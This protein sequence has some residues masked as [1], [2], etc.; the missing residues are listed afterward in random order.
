MVAELKISDDVLTGIEG[1][2]ILITGKQ[3]IYSIEG[4]YRS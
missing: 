4:T 3:P 2:V 1:K